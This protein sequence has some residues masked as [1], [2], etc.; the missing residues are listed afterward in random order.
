MLVAL[1]LLARAGRLALVLSLAFLAA[2]LTMSGSVPS[3]AVPMLVVGLAL[4][5]GS[6]LAGERLR[7]SLEER[8][9]EAGQ[10]IIQRYAARASVAAIE[11]G[12]TG[13]LVSRLARHPGLAAKRLVSVAASKAACGAGMLMGIALMALFSW[14]AALLLL[15]TLPVMILFFV[16]VGG[17]TKAKADRQEESLARL[18][19]AFADRV[20]CLPSILA[21]HAVDKE[22]EALSGELEAYRRETAGLL[23]VAFLNSAVLDFFSSLSIAMLAIFL[24]LGHLGLADVPGF[25]GL[26]LSQSLAILVLAPEIFQP[27]RRHAELYH[28]S[29]EGDVAVAALATL[30]LEEEQKSLRLPAEAIAA[31][32]LVLKQGIGMVD[33]D[34]PAKGLVAI[35]GASGCGKTS[36]LRALSGVDQPRSGQVF[37]PEGDIAWAAADAWL[38]AGR[39]RDHL[40]PEA[41]AILSALNLDQ[42]PRLS[43]PAFSIDEGASALSGGQRLRLGIAF[44]A[45]SD[46]SVLYTDEP[47]AKL[48]EKSASAVRSF[49]AELAKDRLV[50]AATHDE[51]L[52][53]RASLRIDMSVTNEVLA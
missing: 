6:G 34:L 23:R 2:G 52:A 53:R 49:L 14:Q 42:D 22:G 13:D 24:G 31:R 50:I 45:A 36:L 37:K 8:A 19:G 1:Q 30:G 21:N 15:V 41:D 39:L 7:V 29:A 46:A 33:L 11:A 43:D 32:S 25:T 4:S 17:L 44:A 35:T 47:T 3:W 9:A 38:P 40:G 16:F 18:A 5:A 28:Q 26:A 51:E 20:R 10:D 27:L 48:D 12:D